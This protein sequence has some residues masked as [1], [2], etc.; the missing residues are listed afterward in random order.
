L[1]DPIIYSSLKQLNTMATK[2]ATTKKKSTVKKKAVT[3]KKAAVKKVTKKAAPKKKAA[4]KK[5]TKKTVKATAKTRK[6]TVKPKAKATTRKPRA[7]SKWPRGYKVNEVERELILAG[8]K[9]LYSLIEVSGPKMDKA[10]YFV[11]EESAKLWIDKNEVNVLADKALSGKTHGG[12]LGRG[13][14][15]ETADLKA[16]TELPELTTETPDDRVRAYN[17]EDTDR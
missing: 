13:I 10:R 15:K 2:K 17:N 12:M 9:E 3:K 4:V 6:A 1:K 14:M 8:V 5:V 7:K 16:G 11:D